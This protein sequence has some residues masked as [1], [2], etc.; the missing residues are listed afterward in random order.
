MINEKLLTISI[1]SYNVEKC[2]GSCLDSLILKN[3]NFKYLDVVVVNDGSKDNTLNVAKKYVDL[4]PDVFRVVD[5]TNGGYGSTINAS[6]A[7]AK[8][9]YYKLLDADD[10][11]DTD[12][13]NRLID[14]LKNDNEN[15]DLIITPYIKN[16]I[17][18]KKQVLVNDVKDELICG[19]ISL[20]SFKTIPAM[21]SICVKTECIKSMI[22]QE[23]CF[24]TDNEYVAYVLLKTSTFSAM[25]NQV[26]IYNLG[27][28]EQSVS[29]NGL[30]K[31]LN[32]W[33][34][35]Y[36]A[37]KKMIDCETVNSC[38]NEM[39]YKI[40][41]ELVHSMYLA[42]LVQINPIAYKK[43]LMKIDSYIKENDE[44][45]YSLTN[46]IFIIKLL[47]KRNFVLYKPF[48]LIVKRKLKY[49]K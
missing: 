33:Y 36:L 46:Q 21:H 49:V 22:I 2:L 39:I 32:D 25:N 19:N 27:I 45:V 42:H 20:S 43:E 15:V 3:D 10:F 11:F 41:K 37:I 23:H 6:V 38:R 7:I 24:Y 14:F 5:K 47:R 28:N 40:Q 12:G 30:R 9:K 35:V 17:D 8:G 4:Y 13:L 44:I 16:Y 1:A 34:L 48:S 29:V 18:V 31:H 26:Y